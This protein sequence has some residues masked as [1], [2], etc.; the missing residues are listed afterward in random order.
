M[1][2]GKEPLNNTQI[3]RICVQGV[4]E[5]KKGKVMVLFMY[6][7]KGTSPYRKRKLGRANGVD[8]YTGQW[9]VPKYHTLRKSQ[10]FL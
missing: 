1:S 10:Y 5:L 4:A 8:I 9:Y 6:S 7:R 2:L 3:Y